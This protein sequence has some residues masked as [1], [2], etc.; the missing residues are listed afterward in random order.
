M[1]VQGERNGQLAINEV[2]TEDIEEEEDKKPA[3]QRV[4]PNEIAQLDQGESNSLLLEN[5][6]LPNEERTGRLATAKVTT[7]AVNGVVS[8]AIQGN[9][10]QPHGIVPEGEEHQM[11]TTTKQP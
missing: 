11:G 4:E 6:L 1:L 3:A 2:T 9:M 10:L 7:L 8:D 5:I